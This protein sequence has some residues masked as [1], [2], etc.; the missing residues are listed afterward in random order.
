MII[1]LFAIGAGVGSF[2]YVLT[3]RTHNKQSIHGQSRC[4]SCNHK[5]SWF[6]LMP[7]FG[8]LICCGKCRYCKASIGL[9]SVLVEIVTAALFAVS[10]IFWPGVFDGLVGVNLFVLWLI[11]LSG[12]VALALYDF[13]Y[14]KLPNKLIYPVIIVAALFWLVSAI[15]SQQMLQVGHWAEL[16]FAMLPITGV[17]GAVYLASGGGLIGLG[18]VKLGIIAGFLLTWQGTLAVLLLANMFTLIIYLCLPKKQRANRQIP[19]A[20]ALVAAITLIF[21]CYETF[22]ELLLSA[23]L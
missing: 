13:K 21:L 17:Y 5:L 9:G 19:F 10:Y 12:L 14:T 8:W 15:S 18:D 2:I 11:I 6:E 22:H 23:G 1:L 20:P 7:I 16:L 4:D 3:N